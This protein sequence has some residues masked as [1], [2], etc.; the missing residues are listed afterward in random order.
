MLG[1]LYAAPVVMKLAY[2]AEYVIKS[3][4]C[5]F[6]EWAERRALERQHEEAAAEDRAEYELLLSNHRRS[7]EETHARIRE[8]HARNVESL[9]RQRESHELECRQRQR[10]FEEAIRSARDGDACCLM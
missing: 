8:C 5:A 9:E 3:S 2:G 7:F 10:A 4:G 6:V 1:V